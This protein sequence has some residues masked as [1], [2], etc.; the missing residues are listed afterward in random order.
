[1]DGQTRDGRSLCPSL[2]AALA[3]PPPQTQ[4]SQMWMLSFVIRRQNLLCFIN[5]RVGVFRVTTLV[6]VRYCPEIL[7]SEQPT[8]D[9]EANRPVV[10]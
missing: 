6:A 7:S 8:R 9:K 10:I 2:P 3:P 1:M 5:F 4:S